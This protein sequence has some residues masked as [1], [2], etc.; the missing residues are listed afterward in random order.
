[1][2]SGSQHDANLKGRKRRGGSTLWVERERERERGESERTSS[3]GE[4]R[5][6]LDPE[7]AEFGHSERSGAKK[8]PQEASMVTER[9]GEPQKGLERGGL[10]AAARGTAN[11]R[12]FPKNCERQRG[13]TAYKTGLSTLRGP[14]RAEP[15]PIRVAPNVE[16]FRTRGRALSREES[17]PTRLEARQKEVRM[18]LS[19]AR[20]GADHLGSKYL[21][22]GCD[23]CGSPKWEY[24]R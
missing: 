20:D 12:G 2:L 13:R 19:E 11:S 4:K 9:Q 23:I 24:R 5:R 22:I 21:V 15:T 3:F 7:H 14:F 1:L 18:P 10:T 8:E 17:L 16:I 6:I